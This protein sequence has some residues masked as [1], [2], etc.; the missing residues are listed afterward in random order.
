M[1]YEPATI[2]SRKKIREIA[3]FIRT[4]LRIETIKFPVIKVLDLLEQKFPDNLFYSV[5]EDDQFDYKVMAYI[6]TVNY[7]QF[8]IKIRQSVYDSALKNAG[9]SLGFICHELCHFIL[10]FLFN[11]K[12]KMQYNHGGITFMKAINP[13]REKPY[14]SMEWQAKALC[15]ELMIPYEIC[16]SL[17][18]EKIMELTDSSF[19][20]ACFFVDFIAK[21]DNNE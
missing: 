21:E 13:L 6:E 4:I 10:I 16:K 8:C 18:V 20:Q 17:P 9:A 11:I 3:D 2:L 12:P 1:D 5:E 14:R 15:G 19:E 7:T